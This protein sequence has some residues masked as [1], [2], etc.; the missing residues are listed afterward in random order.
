MLR[1]Q[2][3]GLIG[4]LPAAEDEFTTRRYA[5]VEITAPLTLV[6]LREA[7]AVRMGVPTDVHRASRQTLARRWSVAFTTTPLCR[8]ASF[9][10]PA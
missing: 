2:R 5:E 10:R 6:D 8:T 3:D 7:C 9:I 1:D 4:S